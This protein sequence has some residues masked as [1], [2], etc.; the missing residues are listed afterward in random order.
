MTRALQAT[1]GARAD[2]RGCSGIA[3]G[4]FVALRRFCEAVS[5]SAGPLLRSMAG[6][7]TTR[8]AR[9]EIGRLVPGVHSPKPQRAPLKG[10]KLRAKRSV[11]AVGPR[12]SSLPLSDSR[13]CSGIARGAFVA[14]RRFCVPHSGAR[15]PFPAALPPSPTFF[16]LTGGQFDHGIHYAHI[17]HLPRRRAF[18]IP[19]AV[20]INRPASDPGQYDAPALVATLARVAEGGSLILVATIT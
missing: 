3:R 7:P 18:P 10:P 12:G 19:A 11:A 8:S 1:A 14:L 5:P 2:F 20:E 13:G 6:F 15:P 17:E 16:Y 4:A 9:V